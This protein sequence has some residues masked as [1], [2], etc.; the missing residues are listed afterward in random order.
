ML[1]VATDVEGL[2]IEIPDIPCMYYHLNEI[3]SIE[4]DTRDLVIANPF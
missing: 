3:E 2:D 4:T 1:T